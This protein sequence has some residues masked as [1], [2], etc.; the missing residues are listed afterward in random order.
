[1][2]PAWRRRRIGRRLLRAFVAELG[3]ED[4]YCVPYT[5]LVT[6][7]GADGFG[8]VRE[9]RAPPFLRERLAEYRARGL[10]VLLMHRPAGAR[11]H[12]LE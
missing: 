6:F 4:C 2:A 1:V 10:D 8:S 9:E 3:R 11:M 5:H 7:Y 12:G